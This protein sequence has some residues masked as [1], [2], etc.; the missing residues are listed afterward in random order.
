M[1]LEFTIDIDQLA[2]RAQ[3]HLARTDLAALGVRPGETARLARAEGDARATFVR[4]RPGPW[5]PGVLGLDAVTAANAKLSQGAKAHLSPQPLSGLDHV[6]LRLEDGAQAAPADLREALFEMTL[7]TGDRVTLT[8]PMGRTVSAEVIDCGPDQ[9]GLVQDSTNIAL[10]MPHIAHG[11]ENVGGLSSQIARVQEMIELPLRRPDL[12]ARLGLHPPRGVLFTGPPGSGK[13][14]LARA[15][16]RRTKAA[17]YHIS[18]PEIITKHYGESEAGLRKVFQAAEK[19][20]PSIVFIDEIDAIAPARDGLSGDKQVERRLVAQ[21]LTLMDGLDDR[22]RVIVM[23]A[24]N[25][26]DALDPAL[27]RPG[28][29]DR[30]IA[31]TP[32]DPEQRADILRVHLAETPLAED[33]SL[34]EIAIRAHGYVGADLA[35]LTREAAVA[36]L[37]RAIMQ[38]GGE[39]DLDPEAL[40]VTRADLE[41]G[42]A[43][44]FPSALRT[45]E[46]SVRAVGWQDIGGL[47]EAREALY[48]AVLW[49]LEQSKALKALKLAPARGVLLTGPPGSGKTLLARA[50]AAEAAFNFIP[51]RAPTLLSQYFGEAE[52]ALAS[53]FRNARNSAPTVLFFDEFD[54]LAP[55]RSGKDP[56]LDRLVAQL[57]VEIDGIGP[58]DGVIALAATNRA[59][60]ID[61]ALLR[62]GRFDTV[63]DF[64]YPNPTA[65]RAILDVHLRERAVSENI[66]RDACAKALDGASG[67]EIATFCEDAARQVLARRMSGDTEACLITQPDIDMALASWQAGQALRRSD[68]IQE[69]GT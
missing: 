2:P 8:L 66:D 43:A 27:R 29:F 24:T 20:A 30:E 46:T 16:A 6:L 38:S 23:A 9:A 35:A 47:D 10:E 22:G 4:L 12:Y 63:I 28:R 37:S 13:T 48:R 60:A 25:L 21:L 15:V 14:L 68:H 18:G 54:A 1:T 33:V 39:A 19:A 64:P 42:L 52:K 51:V 59:G 69:R 44:T 45:G 36:A 3:A 5:A 17:F 56:V 32:P 34:P 58:D 53:L 11:Y 62:S 61:P 31:F 55:R 40:F 65:R 49:P 57:L 26:P 41:T 50:I 7:A 67:A